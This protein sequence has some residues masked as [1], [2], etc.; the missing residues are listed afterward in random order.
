MKRY[1]I[2]LILLLTINIIPQGVDR[3]AIKTSVLPD[4]PKVIKLTTI[5]SLGNPIAKYTK[6][7]YDSHR[8][9]QQISGFKEGNIITVTGYILLVATEDDGDYHIQIRTTPQ[10]ADSCFIVEVPNPK[11]VKDSA[12]A[13]RCLQVRNFIKMNVLNGKEPTI[14]KVKG[15]HYVTITGQLFF[16]ATHLGATKK[17]VYRGKMGM[18]SYSCWEIHPI[19]NIQNAVK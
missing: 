1:I 3:W 2:L 5:L 4:T 11:F 13:R 18:K 8:I 14:T 15:I 12:L 10:W 19:T 7:L 9:F 16:D 17:G 6:D